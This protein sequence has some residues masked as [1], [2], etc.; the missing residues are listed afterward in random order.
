M[1]SM[2]VDIEGEEAELVQCSAAKGLW[3]IML[4]KQIIG[5]LIVY[6]DDVLITG[7]TSVIHGVMTAFKHEW[8]CKL[9]GVIT[10]DQVESPHSTDSLVFLSITIEAMEGGLKLHQHEYLKDKIVSRRITRTRPNLP[11]VKEGRDLP[12][13]KEEKETSTFKRA[14]N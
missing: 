2:K 7:P 1:T 13:T 3:K 14:L 9:V 11:E 5:Y 4:L 10:K 12:A 8:E 6:V